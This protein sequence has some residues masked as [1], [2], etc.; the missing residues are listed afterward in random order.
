M[1]FKLDS[2]LG[3]EALVNVC[4]MLLAFSGRHSSHLKYENIVWT[5]LRKLLT[6][7]SLVHLR[8]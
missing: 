5:S 7:Y 4:A 1:P 8:C 3:A 2:P 6:T